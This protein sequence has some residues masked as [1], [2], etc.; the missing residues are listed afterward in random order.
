MGEYIVSVDGMGDFATL[1]AASKAARAG[2]VFRVNRGLYR[3]TLNVNVSGVTWTAE[4]G[5]LLDGGWRGGLAGTGWSSLITVSAPGCMVDGFSVV[6]SPGRGIVVNASDTV[7][8]NCYV[9]NTFHGGLMVGDGAGPAISNVTV[10][11]CLF[12]K[13]SQSWVTE[14]NPKNVNGSVNIHNVVDSVFERNMVCDGWGEGV[15]IGRNSQRVIVRG[16]EVHSC[17]HVLLYVNRCQDCVI[18]GNSLYHIPDPV[19]G[20]KAGNSFSAGIVIGDERGKV[21]DRFDFSRGNVIR[22]NVVVN[23]GKMLQVRNNAIT[24]GYDTALTD[25]V[26]E[27]NTFVA[28]PVTATGIDIKSNMRGR[29]HSGSFYRHN[30]V[31]FTYAAAGADIGSFGGAGVTFETNGWSSPPPQSMRSA[32]DVAAPLMLTRPATPISRI[33]DVYTDFNLDDYRPLAESPLVAGQTIGAL[34]AIVPPPPP[35]PDPPERDVAWLIG[36]LEAVRAHVD[37]TIREVRKW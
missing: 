31:E 4:E 20:G 9:E 25:T 17:N 21:L 2:D 13:M 10:R 18:D 28:G 36:E 14:K 24:D 26:I 32:G 23:T 37:D 16:N 5:A 3:E 35:P 19:Y 33:D 6:N 27:N 30:V 7:L 22:G 34:D 1:T 8:E 12:T 15:N 29:Q 11:E